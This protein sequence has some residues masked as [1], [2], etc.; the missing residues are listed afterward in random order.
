MEIGFGIAVVAG[1]LSFASPCVLPIVPGYLTFITGMSFE[2]LV[3]R[4]RSSEVI[5]SAVFRSLPFVLG[6]SLVFMALGAS[7][8]FVSGLI[9]SNLGILK[10]IAGIGIIILGLHL[11]GLLSI[12]PL[13]REKRFSISEGEPGLI[14]AFVA[15]IFFAFGWTPCVGPILAGILA[16]AATSE[17][18]SYGVL[19]LGAY[20]IGLGI[21]FVL[22]AAFMNGF[23]SMFGGIKRYIRQMEVSAGMLL[24][25][26][27][28]LIFTDKLS[29]ISS[30]LDFLN[31]E[32]LL[33]SDQKGG[34]A[35][36]PAA[37]AASLEYTQY[38]DYEFTITTVD[39]E[40]VSLSDYKGKVVLVN[41]WAPW[42]GPCVV[43]T[44][45]LVRLYHKFKHQGFSVVGVA[46]QS[47]EKG[48]QEFVQKHNIPY[49]VGRD[50]SNEIGLSYQ[51][52]ALPS[53]F[54]FSA[55]G[56]VER[57]FTGYVAEN[58]LERELEKVFGMTNSIMPPA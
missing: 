34:G 10:S 40:T 22:S 23:L 54:L 57:A 51:V 47:E 24:V 55:D 2:Q 48:V 32:S 49:A 30:R 7:A 56:K 19:L 25:V 18:L 44:P 11:S 39:G 52:F 20:S 9:R 53:S 21:P 14:R 31:P 41:F 5:A 46:L 50:L 12:Q 45:A 3:G 33:V 13:N 8:S 29:W 17:T 28:L 42:C 27:G 35:V 1:F 38:G 26:L 36:P 16:V 58:V 37:A 15:G 6:F 43:E 4:R